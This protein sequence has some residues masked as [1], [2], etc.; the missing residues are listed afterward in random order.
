M[1]DPADLAHEVLL[2]VAAF[3]KALSADQL[4]DLASGAAKLELVPKGG[5][6]ARAPRA[7]AAPAA[8]PRP[9]SEIETM[10]AELSTRQAATQ[11]LNDLKLTVAQLKELAKVLGV[12]APAKATKAALTTTI[13][14][15]TTGRRLDSLALSR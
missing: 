8:L 15:A 4:A 7:A 11:Y 12:A 5:R 10:L 1:T 3:V 14:D 2:R 6:P 9:V 13:V